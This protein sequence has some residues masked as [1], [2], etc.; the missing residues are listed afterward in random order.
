[1]GDILKTKCLQCGKELGAE[2]F[3]GVVCGKCVRENHRKATGRKTIKCILPWFLIAALF[4]PTFPEYEGED[5]TD[6]GVGCTDDCLEP[7]EEVE[8]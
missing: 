8:I 7:A 2:I 1:M 4:T 3:L 6:S 5:F